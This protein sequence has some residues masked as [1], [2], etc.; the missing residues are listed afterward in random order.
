MKPHSSALVPRSPFGRAFLHALW[1]ALAALLCTATLQAQA[2]TAPQ[3]G[4]DYERLPM[5]Q[6]TD[7][8]G[9]IEVIE[10]FAYWCP[11]CNDFD[12]V[13][14]EW[15][16]RQGPDVVVR[17]VPI[18]FNDAQA[19]LQRIYYVLDAL[20]KEPELR[21][22]VFAAIHID[23]DPLNTPDEQATFAAKNGIDRKKYL[24]LYN[25]F[26]I[27]ARV[28]RASQM[29][30]AYG[31]DSVP[32]LA[33]D[34]KYTLGGRPNTLAVLDQLVAMERKSIGGK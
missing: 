4:R 1:A 25:S 24:D 32:T 13:L 11:H 28:T 27:Q 30:Q 16:K 10:F 9:K 6:P 31:V 34:G 18:A 17:H 21:A 7:S 26:S 29:A 5:A 33:V 20:G 23:N 12:P 19:P 3:A 2:Q 8:P 22:K 15:I 14:N